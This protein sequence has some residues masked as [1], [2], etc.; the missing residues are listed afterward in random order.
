MVRVLWAKTVE[1]VPV[2]E[3]ALQDTERCPQSPFQLPCIE[4]VFVFLRT[5]SRKKR[6]STI[7]VEFFNSIGRLREL[8]FQ[9]LVRKSTLVKL[10]SSV[11]EAKSV[12]LRS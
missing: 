1:K 5:S 12:L 11:S 9:W 6:P 10:A 4:M 3:G 7:V 8:K 2:S